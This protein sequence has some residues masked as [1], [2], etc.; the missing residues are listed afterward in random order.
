MASIRIMLAERFG[1]INADNIKRA[2]ALIEGGKAR[3]IVL[4]GVASE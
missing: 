2:P 3:N 4:E 1:A